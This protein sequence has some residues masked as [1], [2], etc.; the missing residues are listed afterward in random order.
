MWVG[1]VFV[2]DIE[3]RNLGWRLRHLEDLWVEVMKRSWWLGLQ[4]FSYSVFREGFRSLDW[5]PSVSWHNSVFSIVNR[6]GPRERSPHQLIIYVL[7]LCL[8][9]R[10]VFSVYLI[11]WLQ[12]FCVTRNVLCIRHS[13]IKVLVIACCFKLSRFLMLVMSYTKKVSRWFQLVSRGKTQHFNSY[14]E[15]V[16]WFKQYC[17]LTIRHIDSWKICISKSLQLL[18]GHRSC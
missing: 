5:I 9:V 17:F 10:T 8:S 11:S 12:L 7:D 2:L 16:H 14:F 18:K 3:R 13:L 15:K 1:R 4:F 6:K